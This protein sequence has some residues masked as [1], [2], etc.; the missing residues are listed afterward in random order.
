ML[1]QPQ[2]DNLAKTLVD[3]LPKPQ[4]L[5]QIETG[6]PGL[7]LGWAAVPKSHELKELKADLEDTLP[8]PRRTKATAVFSDLD[9]YLAYIHTHAVDGTTTWCDFNPV[10]F[11]LSFTTVIDEHT[12]DAAGWRSHTARFSPRTSVEWD[13]WKGKDR[14]SFGQVEFAEW[15]QE[16][17]DDIASKEGYPTSLQMHEM[18]TN[19]VAN[20]ERQL[21]S[22]VRLQSGGIRLNYIA[23]PDAGTTEA[24][25]LFQKFVL[26]IPVFH[27][28][29]AYV[30]VARL[31]Y[32]LNAG[33][34]SFFYELQRA[35]RAHELAAKE[36]IEQIRAGLGSVPLLMGACG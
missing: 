13:A 3:A 10:T 4:I 8:H 23:D 9:S 6:V 35:D 28:G 1:D 22:T 2:A 32:R 26:G 33:K 7:S 11:A 36:L 31:K 27:G 34:V 21:K 18:A 25:E 5:Q 15:L 24:M 19:F 29:P 30:I 14:K 17:E 12:K 20:E 16:N